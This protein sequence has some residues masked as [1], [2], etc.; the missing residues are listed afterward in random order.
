MM[1]LHVEYFMSW[2]SKQ[3]LQCLVV[4]ASFRSELVDSQGKFSID[5]M[6]MVCR[7]LQRGTTTK[8]E[9]VI[10]IDSKF[11][12]RQVTD[13]TDPQ[14]ENGKP[15]T[16]MVQEVSQHVHIIQVLA[17]DVEK[18]KKVC[19]MW[20]NF[21]KGLQNIVPTQGLN[22]TH[23][24]SLSVEC[25]NICFSYPAHLNSK[26]QQLV[27]PQTRKF[28]DCTQHQMDIYWGGLGSV[29]W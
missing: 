10:H 18:E 14:D 21:S 28:C 29:Q 9:R 17:K 4:D 6:L 3:L 25:A 19:E 12:L 13:K 11:V 20:Q 7:K 22:S 5:R 8:S 16:M 26:H 24:V 23:F 27:L 1:A 15:K 2:P